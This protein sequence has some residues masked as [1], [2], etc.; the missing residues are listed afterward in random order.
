MPT[1]IQANLLYAGHAAQVGDVLTFS[2]TWIS[3][4]LRPDLSTT[5]LPE[6]G[7]FILSGNIIADKSIMANQLVNLRVRSISEGE[8]LEG[9]VRGMIYSVLYDDQGPKTLYADPTNDD[10][11]VIISISSGAQVDTFTKDPSDKSAT[12]YYVRDGG[13]TSEAKNLTINKITSLINVSTTNRK[14]NLSMTEII[15]IGEKAGYTNTSTMWGIAAGCVLYNGHSA[16]PLT[17][18]DPSN[19]ALTKLSWNVT[20]NYSIKY[21]PGVQ[22]VNEPTWDHVFYNGEYTKIYVDEAETDYLKLY[23]R[24]TLPD[25][26]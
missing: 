15:A 24:D 3:H 5:Y 11:N 19:T 14:R 23:P 12:K 8:Y 22:F 10:D 7:D 25:E 16:A 20:H 9:N 17:E 18:V 6:V 21:I 26:T 4:N 13:T 2:E 1:T